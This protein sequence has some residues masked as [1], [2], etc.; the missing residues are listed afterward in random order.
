MA[1]D[2][3]SYIIIR[4]SRGSSYGDTSGRVDT[5]LSRERGNN[6]ELSQT[7]NGRL[8]TRSE[9]QVRLERVTIQHSDRDIDIGSK[10]EET[11]SNKYP[12]ASVV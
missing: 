8:G 10:D 4:V 11:N 9:V 2:Q 12:D 3:F 6:F 5:S 7:R 1:P